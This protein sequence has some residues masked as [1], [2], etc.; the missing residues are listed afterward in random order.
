MFLS[1][2]LSLCSNGW[3]RN[4]LSIV[5]GI[6]LTFAFPPYGWWPA[7]LVSLSGLLLLVNRQTTLRSAFIT[8]WCFGFGHHVTALYWIAN[9]L[10]VEPD[11]FAWLIPFAVSLIPAVLAVYVAVSM[12]LYLW[13]KRNLAKADDSKLV[14]LAIFALCWCAMEWVRGHVPVFDFPWNMLGYVWMR[15]EALLQLASVSGV[16]GL[17]FLACVIGCLPAFLVESRGALRWCGSVVILLSLC[18]VALWGGA[19]M[20]SVAAVEPE[21]AIR[22]RLVQ[23]NIPQNHDW[24]VDTL[25]SI[26]ERHVELSVEGRSDDVKYVVWSESSVP[27]LIRDDSPILDIIKEAVPAGGLLF[28]GAVR[29]DDRGRLYNSIVA[30]NDTGLIVGIYD[31]MHLVPF[32]EFVPFRSILPIE[33]ITHGMTDFSPGEQQDIVMVLDDVLPPV[34]PLLCYEAIFPDEVLSDNVRNR[35]EWLLNLTND[36]WFGDSPGPYQHLAMAR[37]RAIEQGV[38]MI[39]VANTGISAM[40]DA[41]G[42]VVQSLPLGRDG[43]LD[44]N[45]LA[46]SR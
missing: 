7:A 28:T 21:G 30:I 9:S 31:K 26:V 14:E 5:L 44:V 25:L 29:Q 45:L 12:W 8:G 11:K 27:Y 34:R 23:G 1:Q 18:L 15:W 16:L 39:R 37:L 13:L 22:I 2:R 43:V 38:P 36:G 35:P 41:R 17:S 24:D 6:L 42:R 19:R 4:L 20:E 33:K 40:I 32:G 3:R 10:L 46:E